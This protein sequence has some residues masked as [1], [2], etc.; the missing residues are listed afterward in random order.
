MVCLSL[1]VVEFNFLMANVILSDNQNSG[2]DSIDWLKVAEFQKR[3]ILRHGGTVW[4]E[5]KVNEG[6]TFYFSLPKNG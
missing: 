1:Q 3:I 6:A 5:G 2:R 4:A